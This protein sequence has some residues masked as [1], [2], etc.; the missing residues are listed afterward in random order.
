MPVR[1]LEKPAGARF[2][3]GSGKYLPR[4]N[5][6]TGLGGRLGEVRTGA[7]PLRA[8]AHW[9]RARRRSSAGLLDSVEPRLPRRGFFVPAREGSEPPKGPYQGGCP[10][11]SA[12]R[13]REQLLS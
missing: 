12:P 6:A 11:G 9:F 1:P 2:R 3:L 4:L 8:G 13:S 10:K 7:E 5:A